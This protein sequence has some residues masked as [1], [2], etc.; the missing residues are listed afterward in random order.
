MDYNLTKE[1]RKEYSDNRVNHMKK[2]RILIDILIVIIPIIL[3][4]GGY[5]IYNEYIKEPGI[6]SVNKLIKEKEENGYQDKE[7]NQI[8]VS[9]YVNQLPSLRS[10]YGNQDIMG[11]IEIPNL[12]ID[13]LVVRSNDNVYY[14][15][16]SIYKQ[17][18]GLGVPFFDFRNTNLN[19]ARQIN[20]YGHNTLKE[21]YYDQLP[22]TN[23]EAYVNKNIFLNYRDVYLSIDERQMHYEVVAIKI[24]TVG[25]NEHM[26]VTF[27]NDSD[28]IQHINRMVQGS[29][30]TND[31]SFSAN[32]RVLVLQICHY[33]PMGSYLLV[34]CK[35]KD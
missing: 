5:Y 27:K 33:E 1:N 13:A 23:L 31:A 11:K 16:N 24:I 25:D 18:D 26:K 32:D 22:F 29:I 34:I 14:L 19:T 4:V 8:D 10:Q 17:K 7:D 35:E 3:C 2:K 15:N 9:T 30:Y 6:P 12:N 21:E 20:I 28:F